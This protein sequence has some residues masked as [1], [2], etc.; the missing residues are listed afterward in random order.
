M[1][2]SLIIV[3]SSKFQ[4]GKVHVSHGHNKDVFD[5]SPSSEFSVSALA[6]YADVTHEVEPVTSG[7]RLAISYN[8]VDTSRGLPPAHLPDMHSGV[9]RVQRIFR[10]WANGEYDRDGESSGTIVYLLDH[11]YSDAGLK[12][13]AL[14]G[15]DNNLVSN[16]RRIAEKEGVCLRLGCL[17]YTVSGDAGYDYG[18]G[19]RS[20]RMHTVEETEYRIDYLYDLE[21][22]LTK[23][24]W[25]IRP[26]EE[27]DLIPQN[28]FEGKNP[29]GKEFDGYT[30]NVSSSPASRDM[31]DLT[32]VKEGAPLAY[33]KWLSAV[34]PLALSVIHP[35]SIVYHRTALV[36][37]LALTGEES[38]GPLDAAD[39]FQKLKRSVAE[40]PTERNRKIVQ[41]ILSNGG[42][43]PSYASGKRKISEDTLL[44]IDLAVEWNDFAMWAKVLKKSGIEESPQLLGSAPLIRAW[45]AFPFNVTRQMFVPSRLPRPCSIPC[46]YGLTSHADSKNSFLAN[47]A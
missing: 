29:D 18:Y 9:S 6:W 47:L 21:G 2:A 20:P 19:R 31:R 27:F 4:G 36:M 14:K 30:G 44:L 40:G 11:Q 41:F 42:L 12:F 35:A 28:P 10:M 5:V 39:A 25:S 37:Y 24:K 34:T 23:L 33:C 1:F 15:K 46:A 16:I 3:L 38:E 17:V 32:S 43:W 7:Y 13:A 45:N 8:L 22:G 26:S